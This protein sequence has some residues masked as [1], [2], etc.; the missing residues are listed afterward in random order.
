M[1]SGSTQF[2]SLPSYRGSSQSFTEC[3]DVDV[4]NQA[5]YSGGSGFETITENR[6]F[7][8]RFWYFC[9]FPPNKCWNSILWY[10]T[11][12]SFHTLSNASLT[13]ILTSDS[14]NSIIKYHNSEYQC[15]SRWFYRWFIWQRCITCRDSAPFTQTWLTWTRTPDVY[16]RDQFYLTGFKLATFRL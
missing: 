11:I 4:S 2:G 16:F 15:H 1:Y 6:L 12:F 8:L 3:G 9:C 14:W 13:P 10:A 5:I 7:L